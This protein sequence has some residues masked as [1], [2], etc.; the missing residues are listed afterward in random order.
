MQ[1]FS[2]LVKPTSSLCNLDCTY[3]FYKRVTEVYPRSDYAQKMA[4]TTAENM[5]KKYL[6]FKFPAVSL[7]FQG[8]EPLLMGL[9]FYR[10]VIEFE[11]KYGFPGQAI[12]N[13]FQTN[14]VLIDKEWASFFKQYN[15]LIGISLDGEADVHDH[16]RRS[17]KG[18]GSHGTVMQAISTL[19]DA[20]VDFNILSMITSHSAKHI[21]ETYTF[22][23][24]EGFNFLQF[25]PCLELIG[26]TEKIA[27]FSITGDEFG[28]FLKTLFDL[29]YDNGYPDV[30]I[31]MF[32]NILLYLINNE[33]HSCSFFNSCNTYFLIEHNGDVYPCDFF[34]FNEWKLGNINESDF[35]DMINSPKRHEFANMKSKVSNTCRECRYFKFCI[36][37]CTRFRIFP[38]RSAVSVSY[39]CPGFKDFLAYTEK[40][41]NEL[42]K[43]VI[44]RREGQ[45]VRK[46]IQ[47]PENYPRN[48][49]C[50]CG[51]G[52]KYK[53]C[54]GKK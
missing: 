12:G 46:D 44:K 50:P 17:S 42:K 11:K 16:Y 14:G 39:L 22:F 49:Q 30:S 35:R 19:S 32:D 28:E 18:E 51:S 33:K 40:R 4:L 27:E 21:R 47:V 45:N 37:D 24:K 26:G 3:C 9:D 38:H 48:A 54:C 41:F 29:W 10:A 31:R 20:Q 53:Q 43:D 23:R 8:G 15:M 7:C 13:S 1:P 34:V 5:I 6:S 52:K 2:L 25:I 36:G